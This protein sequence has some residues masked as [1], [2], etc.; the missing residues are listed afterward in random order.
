MFK[1]MI[2]QA[3]IENIDFRVLTSNKFSLHNDK[4]S[5]Q[6]KQSVTELV[7]N[8]IYTIGLAILLVPFSNSIVFNANPRGATIL[9]PIIRVYAIFWR[10]PF[11]LRYF[12]GNLIEV[13][14]GLGLIQNKVFKSIVLKSD[15]VFLESMRQINYF[16]PIGKNVI[17]LPNAR[18]S[19]TVRR[20]SSE[21][22]RRLV[23]ISQIREE[24][25]IDLV[26]KFESE[27][28]DSFTI[29]IYGPIYDSKYQYLE[30]LPCYQGS[31]EPDAVIAKLSEYDIL[32]FPTHYPGEGLPGVIIEANSVGLP[33]VTTNWLAI[34]EIVTDAENGLLIEANNYN[35]MKAALVGVTDSNFQKM[36]KCALS[37]AKNY[38]TSVVYGKMLELILKL[39]A[40]SN[41]SQNQEI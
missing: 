5:F 23:F 32:L 21:Y 10:K 29:H 31:L 28:K 7:L 13:F 4:S 14:S 30:S 12:G 24:K 17:Y 25:G 26:L 20:A 19:H 1:L 6:G 37:A 11:V 15:I 34:P 33:V 27:F 39:A 40:N 38:E 41:K 18:E 35:E 9:A 36:S 2:D 22:K 16:R 3:I 8:A